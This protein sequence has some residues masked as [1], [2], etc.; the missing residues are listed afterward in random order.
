MYRITF[1]DHA[2]S[3]TFD[4]DTFEGRRALMGLIGELS[5]YTN[6]TPNLDLY[7]NP[8]GGVMPV[9]IKADNISTDGEA[10]AIIVIREPKPKTTP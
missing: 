9:S 4:L 2:R 7:T 3:V 10:L 1:E 6:H 8:D 5:K